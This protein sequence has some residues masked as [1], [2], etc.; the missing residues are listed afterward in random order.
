MMREGFLFASTKVDA[1]YRGNL[2]WGIRN[3]SIKVVRLKQGERIFK[4]TFMELGK[5]EKPDKY[6]GEH[7]QDHYQNT[8]GIKPSA[9]TLPVDIPERMLVRRSQRKVDPMKQLTQA[10]YPFNH[11]GTELIELQGKF[12][13]VSKDVALVKNGFENLQRVIGEKIEHETGSLNKTISEAVHEIDGKIR[14]TFAEQFG[15]YFDQ[16]MLRVYGVVFGVF[17]A[18]LGLYKVVVQSTPSGVQ[19]YVLFI[20]GVLVLL[21]TVLLTRSHPK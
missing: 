8:K 18:A 19:G 21:G 13:I 11:I 16:R 3:S 12:E 1:G 14:A 10:G 2:N 9:R 6:Y 20:L 4:L 5:E 17:T 15:L 7:Q